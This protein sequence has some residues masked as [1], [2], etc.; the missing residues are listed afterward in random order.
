[1]SY[2][3]CNRLMQD[4]NNMGDWL[5]GIWGS[6]YYL[7]NFYVNLHTGIKHLLEKK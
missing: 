5:Q 6:H 1:M 7:R 2:D 3:K 4:V